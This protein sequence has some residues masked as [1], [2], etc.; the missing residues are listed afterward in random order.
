MAVSFGSSL[1]S[2]PLSRSFELSMLWSAHCFLSSLTFETTVSSVLFFILMFC[3]LLVKSTGDMFHHGSHLIHEV[4]CYL[5]FHLIFFRTS[6]SLIF[7]S[8]CWQL[9]LY[10][11]IL[12]STSLK[13]SSTLLTFFIKFW[14]ESVCALYIFLLR[15]LGKSIGRLLN[16]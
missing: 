14:I 2:I 10:L 6:V 7:S 13:F 9:H 11:P 15:S 4:F 16:F 5:Y 12:S 3:I 8:C 1:S